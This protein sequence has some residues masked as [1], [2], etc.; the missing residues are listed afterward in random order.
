MFKPPKK[1]N[2]T[3]RLLRGS[4][5][6]RPVSASAGHFQGD[7]F[8]SGNLSKGGGSFKIDPPLDPENKSLYHS[9][10]ESPDMMNIYNGNVTTDRDGEAVVTLPDWFEALNRDF[11]YQLTVIGTFAQAIVAEKVKGNRFTIRTNAPN[12]EV[13]WQ[14]T[15]IR[16]DAYA[17]A[18]RVPVEE[19]KS[20]PERGH[21]L[22]PDAF[23]QPAEKGVEHARYPEMMKAMKA[24]REAASQSAVRQ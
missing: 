22:H 13:S 23:N 15:G 17:N 19:Q 16:Q 10:V 3:M 2:S 8:I 5:S 12:V 20:G 14:V 1:R 6:A 4:S 21:Y 9:F 18:H 7:V 24:A 11:R